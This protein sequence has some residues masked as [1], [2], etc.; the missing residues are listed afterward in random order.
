LVALIQD[1]ATLEVEADGLTFLADSVVAEQIAKDSEYKGTP[2]LMEARMDNVRLNI[3]Q[4]VGQT[5]VA[6]KCL[7]VHGRAGEIPAIS[8]R[9]NLNCEHLGAHPFGDFR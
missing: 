2:I 4:Q 1:C 3:Q 7:K 8:P 9:V 5:A 6:A